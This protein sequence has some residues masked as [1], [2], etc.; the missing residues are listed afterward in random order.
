M[1]SPRSLL[2]TQTGKVRRRGLEEVE[3]VPEPRQERDNVE[4]GGMGCPCTQM[5]K[6]LG[7]STAS[8]T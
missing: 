4:Q 2:Q 6:Y 7:P 8:H 3:T 1:L 5:G